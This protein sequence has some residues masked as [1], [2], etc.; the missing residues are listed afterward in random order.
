[1]DEI[2][3]LIALYE[4]KVAIKKNPELW[5]KIVK[6]MKAG[7]YGG[8]SGEWNARK[9]QLAVKKYKEQGGGYVG[10]KSEENSLHK[11]TKQDWQYDESGKRYLPK[12]AWEELTPQEKKLLNKTK[13]KATKQGKQFAKYPKEVK[14][15]IMKHIRK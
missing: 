1:M 10:K 8:K 9:A 14:D 11:W 3:E 5:D 7:E 4:N 6:E 13:E 15:K 12:K 2:F